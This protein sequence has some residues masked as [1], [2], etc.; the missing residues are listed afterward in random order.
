V[1]INNN[2]SGNITNPPPSTTSSAPNNGLQFIN[3]VPDSSK[4]NVVSQPQT[5]TN[6]PAPAV[7]TT[8]SSPAEVTPSIANNDTVTQTGIINSDCQQLASEDFFQKVRRKMAS[9]S[10]DE[11][12]FHLAQKYFSGG[13]CFSTQQIQSLTYLFIT[14]EYKFK[15][16]EI[17]YLHTY[18]SS[19]FPSLIKTL[20]NDYYR[21]RF[22]AMVR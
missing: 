4:K 20:G 9:R 1:S 10:N 7:L 15:F 17:A 22:K 6:N 5:V 3:F 8:G 13:T 11:G 14:D 2:V 21:G 19:H 18:D 16:L 12:M